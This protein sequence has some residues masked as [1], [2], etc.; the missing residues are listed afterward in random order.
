MQTGA[1]TLQWLVDKYEEQK[2]ICD[3]WTG[4]LNCGE[5]Q[6]VRAVSE[7]KVTPNKFLMESVSGATNTVTGFEEDIS[8]G[9]STFKPSGVVHQDP[10]EEHFYASVRDK[11]TWWRIDD[12]CGDPNLSRKQYV[13]RRGVLETTSGVIQRLDRNVLFVLL[14]KKADAEM[15]ESQVLIFYF[16]NLVCSFPLLNKMFWTHSVNFTI[17]RA[18]TLLTTH[19]PM[20]QPRTLR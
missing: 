8:W 19:S 4:C 9:L 10:V 6:K 1:V 16:L 18:E 15:E 17:C 14:E 3:V 20:P 2:R 5:Q 11:N 12:F 13:K 7:L